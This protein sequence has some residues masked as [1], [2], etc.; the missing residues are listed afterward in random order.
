M[1]HQKAG[2]KLN[3]TAS[4]R[5]AMFRNMVTSLFKHE[6]I[7]TT[8]AKAKELRRWAD[9]L[10]TLA[11]RG[12]L[13]ARRQALA[14]LREKGVVHKLF[15]DAAT[16]FGEKSG[17]YTRIVKLGTRAGDAAP[18]A[19]VELVVPVETR[20]KKKKKK[21]AAAKKAAPAPPPVSA[22]KESAPAEKAPEAKPEA[23]VE[24]AEE[25][26]E[27]RAAAPPEPQASEAAASPEEPPEEAESD[28]P[29]KQ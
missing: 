27:R 14:V 7:R 2:L 28:S 15:E 17:G 23:A 21:A 26:T 11:K 16:R 18:L 1:R 8:D 6:R 25:T 19:L 10:I 4:H 29:E 12:D 5:N 20:K 22:E 3:R 13:H 9:R 24:A